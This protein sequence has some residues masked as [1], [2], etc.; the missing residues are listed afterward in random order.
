MNNFQSNRENSGTNNN[1]CFT[2]L[3]GDIKIDMA[4]KI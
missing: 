2:E 1:Y 4:A 3:K